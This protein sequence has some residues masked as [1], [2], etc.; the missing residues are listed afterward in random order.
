MYAVGYYEVV[1]DLFRFEVFDIVKVADFSYERHYSF[2][3]CGRPFQR[4]FFSIDHFVP[5]DS[6]QVVGEVLEVGRNFLNH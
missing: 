3:G 2:F 5:F 1:D 4:V 6:A